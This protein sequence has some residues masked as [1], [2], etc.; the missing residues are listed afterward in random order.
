M[1]DDFF[2]VNDKYGLRVELKSFSDVGCGQYQHL[3]NLQ[4]IQDL[5]VERYRIGVWDLVDYDYEIKEDE[6]DILFYKPKVSWE[7]VDGVVSPD[8]RVCNEFTKKKEVLHTVWGLWN[9]C[10]CPIDDRSLLVNEVVFECDYL[11]REKGIEELKKVLEILKEKPDS[12]YFI[13]DHNGKCPHLHFISLN[14]VV[15]C[16][17]KALFLSGKH[18]DKSLVNRSHLVRCVG[19][20]YLKGFLRSGNV[21][22]VSFCSAF[23]SFEDITP[24][25]DDVDVVFPIISLKIDKSEV[26]K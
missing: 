6:K 11:S 9:M 17:V 3:N 5:Y 12:S 2:R 8:L 26:K 7:V 16:D 19:G 20:K 23:S 14:P 18:F 13:T 15:L 21:K 24:V 1:T 25:F 10:V 22:D 4:G